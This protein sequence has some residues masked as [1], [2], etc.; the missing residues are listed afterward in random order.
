VDPAADNKPVDL[1]PE[2]EWRGLLYQVTDH[3]ALSR[4]LSTEA[5]TVYAGFD[6]SQP[7]LQ[8]GNL[9]QL[10]TLRRFQEAGHRPVVLA[11]GGTGMIGD[12]GG[13]TAERTLLGRDELLA[14]LAAVRGQLERFVDLSRGRGLLVDNGVWLGELRLLDFLRDVGKHFTVNQMVAKESVKARFEGRDQ[15]ISFTEFTYMLLQAYDFLHLYDT[16]GCRLQ[17]GG[18]D[19]WGNITMGV[20]LI[21]KVREA[22]AFGLTSPLLLNADGTKLGKTER[23]TVWLDPQR[24]PPYQ[25]YQF[26]VRADDDSV[27]SYVRY[28]TW[29]DHTKIRE[30]D[31]ATAANPERREAQRVLAKEVTAL[32]HGERDAARAVRAA[33]ALFDGDLAELDEALLRDVFADAPSYTASRA[34][35]DGEGVLIVELAAAGGLEASRSAA[36]RSVDGKALHVNNVVVTDVER[37]VTRADLLHDRWVVLRRGRHNYLLVEFA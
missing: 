10:C 11:G 9:L 26:F 35:L 24:T 33:Q 15:G 28:F 12:P 22:Q 36:R 3:E 16:Y 27:M 17:F 13:K 20:E 23:G 18:S 8:V 2:L 6:P 1:L 30:L 37:R 5:V 19:Q 4:L 31:Q 32:V 34:D 7:S 14:N 21:R 25:L 29:L